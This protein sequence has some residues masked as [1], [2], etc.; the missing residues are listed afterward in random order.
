MFVWVSA[1][2]PSLSPSPDAPLSQAIIWDTIINSDSQSH[3]LNPLHLFTSPPPPKKSSKS[4]SPTAKKQTPQLEP[5]IIRLK[6]AKQKYIITDIS[7]V[8]SERANVTL[9]VGWN[10][11]P[12]VGALLWAFGEGQSLGRWNG[13]KGG[14]SKAF[15]MPPLKGKSASV[16]ASS[17]GPKAAEASG[18]I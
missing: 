7:G 17:G 13:V 14:R 11:Q 2:Y 8:I 5:G 6:N 15:D 16:V 3:P 1:T 18:V 9:E 4:K 12:W 10:V